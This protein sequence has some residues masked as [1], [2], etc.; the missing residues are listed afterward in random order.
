[1]HQLPSSIGF[2]SDLPLRS[3]P[4]HPS[5]IISRSD[6]TQR[7]V[8]PHKWV[9]EVVLTVSALALACLLTVVTVATLLPI[10]LHQII[11]VQ[12]RGL[13]PAE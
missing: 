2:V 11:L 9:G 7:R 6:A 10:I 8:L 12:I 4:G 1:M 5:W 13:F 3:P